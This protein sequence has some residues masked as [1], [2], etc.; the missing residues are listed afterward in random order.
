MRR[1]VMA[2]TSC[3]DDLRHSV[4]QFGELSHESNQSNRGFCPCDRRRRRKRRRLP[5]G[6]PAMRYRLRRCSG[7]ALHRPQLLAAEFARQIPMGGAAADPDAGLVTGGRP[8]AS[9]R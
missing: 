1:C 8:A 9:R 7:G 5:L 6:G 2:I 4:L 3:G